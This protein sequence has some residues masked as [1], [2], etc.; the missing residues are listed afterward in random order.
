[1]SDLDNEELI[2]TRRLNGLE[3]N[4]YKSADEMFE[5]LGYVKFDNKNVKEIRFIKKMNKTTMADISFHKVF[6]R[7]EVYFYDSE[8]CI[9]MTKPILTEELQAINKKVEELGWI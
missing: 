6:K 1:M 4:L 9:E 3:D 8:Q 5:E 7:I 2:A